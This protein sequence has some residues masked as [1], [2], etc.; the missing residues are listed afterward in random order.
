MI[1]MLSVDKTSASQWKQGSKYKASL[2]VVASMPSVS[3]YLSSAMFNAVPTSQRVE[4]WDDAS[5]SG[6]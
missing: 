2:T 1:R 5:V 3:P 6:S 4:L